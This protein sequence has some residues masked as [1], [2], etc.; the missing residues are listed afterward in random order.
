MASPKMIYF[1]VCPGPQR[2]LKAPVPPSAARPG[3]IILHYVGNTV[4]DTHEEKWIKVE[5]RLN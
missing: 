1:C 5:R 4:K 3:F 2:L